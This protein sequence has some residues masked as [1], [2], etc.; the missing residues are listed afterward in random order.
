MFWQYAVVA[1][2]VLGALYHL[3]RRLWAIFSRR[4]LG[5][6]G[7]G[8]AGCVSQGPLSTCDRERQPARTGSDEDAFPV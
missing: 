2:V 3:G 8:C 6:C 7:S 4:S 5:L 1:I